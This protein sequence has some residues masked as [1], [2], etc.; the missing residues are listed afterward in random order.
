M[1]ASLAL[2]IMIG[3]V[4]AF[5]ASSGKSSPAVKPDDCYAKVPDLL[6][7]KFEALGELPMTL[8]G[9]IGGL[10][11]KGPFGEKLNACFAGA[12][13]EDNLSAGEIANVLRNCRPELIASIRAAVESGSGRALEELLRVDGAH[14]EANCIRAVSGSK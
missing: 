7:A 13:G 1:A 3:V 2:P 11:G 4:L 6:I 14:A 12:G 10:F 8:Q 9:G 5:V